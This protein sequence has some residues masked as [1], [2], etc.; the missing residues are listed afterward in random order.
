MACRLFP[1][2]R[3]RASFS[4]AGFFPAAPGTF[5]PVPA[6]GGSSLH[7]TGL[8]PGEP[9]P[10]PCRR[11]HHRDRMRYGE[12]SAFHCFTEVTTEVAQVF[13]PAHKPSSFRPRVTRYDTAH[14]P[15]GH[16][17][18]TWP[19]PRDPTARLPLTVLPSPGPKV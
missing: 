15:F 10:I 6:G 18:F 16:M 12:A 11:A 19:A 5:Q 13:R 7:R 14:N 1:P 9:V 8:R 3:C 4:G 17:N 2:R